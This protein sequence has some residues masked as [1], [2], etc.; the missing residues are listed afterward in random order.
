MADQTKLGLR[1]E[2]IRAGILQADDIIHA[3]QGDIR[4]LARETKPQGLLGADREEFFRGMTQPEYD[5]L[6]EIAFSM[7]PKGTTKLQSILQEM[8]NL[9]EGR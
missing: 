7:G 9:H 4:Q 6:Q 5:T 2:D 1:G 3:V 8:V